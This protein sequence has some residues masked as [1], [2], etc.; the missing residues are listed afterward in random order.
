MGRVDLHLPERGVSESHWFWGVVRVEEAWLEPELTI[1]LGPPSP[2]HV[3]C[4][5]IRCSGPWWLPGSG[6]QRMTVR[7]VTSGTWAWSVPR[8]GGERGP[9]GRASRRL[10][11]TCSRL[12]R[13]VLA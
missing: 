4:M 1:G 8:D 3:S 5:R 11:G 13:G 10:S 6:V 2:H 7:E 9:Q 12:W